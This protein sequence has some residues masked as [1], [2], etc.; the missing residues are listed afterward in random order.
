[1][2]ESLQLNQDC[3][4]MLRGDQGPALQFAMQLVERAAGV[5]G[6][7]ELVPVGFAHIDACFYSGRAH[8]DFAR[9]M[10]E[11][12]AR[13]EIPA[14]TNNGLVSLANER[15]RDPKTEMARGAK[16]LMQLYAELGCRTVW[17]CAPYQLP[18]G[19]GF[20][21]HIV[22]GESNA[23][24]FYNAAV[25]ARTNK[26]GDYLDVAC[27]LTG[28]APLCGLHTDEGRRAQVL[29]DTSAVPD[30]L[31]RQDIYFHLLGTVMGQHAGKQVPAIDALDPEVGDDALKAISAAAAAAG[32]V[33]H[34]H[35][36]GRTPEAPDR[37]TAFAGL[38][39][40]RTI[41]VTLDTLAAA[42]HSLTSASDG[43]IEMVALG[44]PHFSFTE[45]AELV[46]LLQGRRINPATKLYISTSRHVRDLAAQ[47][48]WADALEKAGA[49]IIVDT[50]TYFSP[51]VRGCTGRVMTNA[52]KWAWYAPGMLGVEVCF[53]SLRECAE[54]AVK[55]EVWRDQALWRG[56]A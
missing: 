43:T 39:P 17:T 54:S 28:Y 44:T 47:N 2:T 4:A 5:M 48:G 24:S 27:G 51:A 55:G 14:W 56:L 6:A 41:A 38:D 20:G 18:G 31:K 12:G 46:P 50:C 1:M 37:D 23:V 35:G 53:G 30:G 52:A 22:V 13:F 26:Y 15:I 34:W 40:T 33:E 16:E 3:A 36:I 45:F 21:D 42:R 25:G 19:P 11:A 29:F 49:E 32:G 10:L 8:V 9:F 7:R